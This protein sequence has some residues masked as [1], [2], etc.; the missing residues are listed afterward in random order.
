MNG[1]NSV[2]RTPVD[3]QRSGTAELDAQ[4]EPPVEVLE[5]VDQPHDH[6]HAGQDEDPDQLAERD[7]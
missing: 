4:P 2:T 7:R 1:P 6:D 5:I 3:G